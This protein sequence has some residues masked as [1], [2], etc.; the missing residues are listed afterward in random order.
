MVNLQK[1]IKFTRKQKESL[2]GL[3]EF[4]TKNVN[5]EQYRKEIIN[6]RGAFKNLISI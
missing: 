1:S 6:I 3:T 5:I 4:L 2:E